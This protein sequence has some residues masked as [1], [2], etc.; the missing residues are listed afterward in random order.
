MQAITA[1]VLAGSA[2][3]V[4][5]KLAGAKNLQ[6]KRSLLLMVSSTGMCHVAVDLQ[7]GLSCQNAHV[8]CGL[9]YHL[10]NKLTVKMI[11]YGS[12]GITT[13]FESILR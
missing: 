13:C 4:A 11:V 10:K 9:E 6:L 5:Q 1:G 8:E 3:M 12:G 7:T 2:D